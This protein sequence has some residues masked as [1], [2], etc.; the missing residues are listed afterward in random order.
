MQRCR[1]RQKLHKVGRTSCSWGED[2][3]DLYCYRR[4]TEYTSLEQT[5]EQK[6]D[7]NVSMLL[8]DM[9]IDVTFFPFG[10]RIQFSYRN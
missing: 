3:L 7:P 6:K 8:G 9:N 4:D 10:Q 1:L 2:D 5:K